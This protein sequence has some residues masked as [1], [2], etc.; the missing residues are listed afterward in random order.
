MNTPNWCQNKD[1]NRFQ[2]VLWDRTRGSQVL[3]T[4]SIIGL[5]CRGR[6]TVFCGLNT[7]PTCWESSLRLKFGTG[8]HHFQCTI[9]AALLVYFVYW[10]DEEWQHSILSDKSGTSSV[11][12][13]QHQCSPEPTGGSEGWICLDCCPENESKSLRLTNYSHHSILSK[14]LVTFPELKQFP[15]KR[16]QTDGHFSENNLFTVS[17]AVGF[18]YISGK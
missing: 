16:S 12:A 18:L 7:E 14:T 8:I 10:N 15:E 3:S 4:A 9:I 6:P 2:A 13:L 17:C 5:Q 1:N 11:S